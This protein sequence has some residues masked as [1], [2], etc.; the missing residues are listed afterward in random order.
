LESP[1]G[2]QKTTSCHVSFD[3]KMRESFKGKA[4]FMLG[5]HK[6][7]TP[8]A[9]TCSSVASR[10]LVQIALTIAAL[11]DSDVSLTC[12]IHDACLTADCREPAWIQ[13]GPQSRSE[14]GKKVLVKKALCG[15]KSSGAALRAFLAER[16]RATGSQAKLCR[17]RCMDATEDIFC[18]FVANVDEGISVRPL[19]FPTEK[20]FLAWTHPSTQS[21][22]HRV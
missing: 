14:A 13:A 6:T 8:S 12:D 19:W 22:N 11:N 10:D 4:H 21:N 3:V 5:R 16:P 15:L 1:P 18:V 2:C 7:K 9:M 17:P 20:L